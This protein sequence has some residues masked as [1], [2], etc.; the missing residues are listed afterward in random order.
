[1]FF[2]SILLMLSLICDTFLKVEN[3]KPK[4]NYELF[5]NNFI[6]IDKKKIFLIR[7]IDEIEF[8]DQFMICIIQSIIRFKYNIE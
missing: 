3:S 4:K 2:F 1:M 6:F 7:Y 5:L 8:Q